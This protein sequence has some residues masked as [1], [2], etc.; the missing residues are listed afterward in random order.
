LIKENAFQ[1]KCDAIINRVECD[2]ALANLKRS[3]ALRESEAENDK[4][5][6]VVHADLA[7]SYFKMGEFVQ[8]ISSNGQ[9]SQPL[10]AKVWYQRSLEIWN[11]LRERNAVRKLDAKTFEAAANSLAEYD[12]L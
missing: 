9:E 2:N 6:A 7:K 3:I 1:R 4:L 5:N 12:K 8:K 11:D 10:E